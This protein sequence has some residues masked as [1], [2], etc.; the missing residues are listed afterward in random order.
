V[1]AHLLYFFAA[2]QGHRDAALALASLYDPVIFDPAA[3]A[4]EQPD[5]VQAHK[6]Y[7]RAA[8]AGD[9]TAQERLD[10]LRLWLEE[11]ARDG[12]QGARLLLMRW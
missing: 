7:L 8:D 11:A 3:S 1:D 6:W 9:T 2:R 4:L 12:D 5:P 10:A